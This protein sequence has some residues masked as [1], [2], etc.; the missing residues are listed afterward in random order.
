MNRNYSATIRSCYL[1][2]IVQAIVNGFAPLLFVTFENQYNIP[3]SKITLLITVNFLLQLAIDGL[4]AWFV[5][6]IGY[7]VSAVA[8][9]V[10]AA[11]GMV[12]LGILPEVM[13]DPF[14][15]LTISVLFYAVG[16]GLI[17][18]IIS[19]MVEAC[20]S[21]HKDKRMSLL[22]SFY[23]WGSVAVI[24]VSTAVFKIFG[25]ESWR[26]LSVLWAVLPAVNAILLCFVPMVSLEDD[27][28]EGMSLAQLL[29]SK[30][31]WLFLIIMCCAGA[32]ELSV[33]QWSSAFAEKALGVSK[34]TGDI[35]GPALFAVLMGVSRVIYGKYGDKINLDRMMIYST[36]L[37]VASYLIICLSPSS[38]V[39]LVGI[40]ISGFSVGIMWPGTYSKASASI[41]GGGTAMFAFL[42]LAGDLGCTLGPTFAGRISAV[43][44][45]NLKIGLLASVV[46]P[47]VLIIAFSALLIT[48]KRNAD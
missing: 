23:C 37:C 2:Y 30:I 39:G 6:K 12:L 33:G 46:F 40:A 43:C 16:G 20:P 44:G 25:I 32:S 9:H 45:N 26:H 18:V 17:E 34:T 47:T 48:I 38:G 29:K 21:D 13:N 7:R 22:H 4:S 15:G 11:I 31:F 35:L 14:I 10:A 41:K 27:Q 36:V 1:G 24:L 8:A 28:D 5:P 3:L 19:P 42:A